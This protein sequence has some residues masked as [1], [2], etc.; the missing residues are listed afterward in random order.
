[1]IPPN[2]RASDPGPLRF[3]GSNALFDDELQTRK[4]RRKRNGERRS[5][6]VASED[7]PP[8]LPPPKAGAESPFRPRPRPTPTRCGCRRP[9]PAPS[10]RARSR[11]RSAT[12]REAVHTRGVRPPRGHRRPARLQEPQPLGAQPADLLRGGAQPRSVRSE[13]R[14]AWGSAE[15]RWVRLCRGHEA[16]WRSDTIELQPVAAALRTQRSRAGRRE[17]S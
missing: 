3:E 7:G 5:E 15:R 14:V 6:P 1:M 2:T 16:L 10:R 11:R 9:R 13:A 12:R 8:P 4:I 17:L